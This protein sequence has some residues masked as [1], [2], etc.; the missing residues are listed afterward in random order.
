MDIESQQTLDEIVDR[1]SRAVYLAIDR[2]VQEAEA[3]IT[4]KLES[5]DGWTVTIT[6]RKPNA[7]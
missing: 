3:A 2:L 1:A 5:L 4:R 6:L 7:D